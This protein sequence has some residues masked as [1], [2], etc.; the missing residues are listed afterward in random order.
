MPTLRKADRRMTVRLAAIATTAVLA[1]GFHSA[2]IAQVKKV[3]P[4]TLVI[5]QSPWFAGFKGLVDYY[6]ETTGNQIK[7]DVNPFAGS[8]EKQRNSARAPASDI[9]L[10]I[11]NAAIMAE[12]WSSGLVN[13]MDEIDPDFKL[14]PQISTFA[15]TVCWD[16]AKASYDCSSGKLIGVPINPNVQMLYYRTDLYEEKGLSVPK[17][18]ADLAS[19]AAALNDPPS[20]F[21]IVQRGSRQGISYNFRPYLAGSGASIFADPVAGDYTVTVNSDAAK[22]ALSFYVGLA[23]EGGHP[24]TGAIAM[25]DMIQLMATGKAA[26]MIAVIAAFSQLDDPDKSIIAGKFNVAVVP[27]SPSTPTLGHFIS[28]IPKNIPQ[29]KKEAVVEFLKWFMTK[30]AQIKYAEVGGVPVRD[31]VL[32]S[33]LADKDQFRWMRPLADSL[34]VA[35]IYYDIPQGDEI[36][37]ILELKLNQAVIGELTTEQALDEA[38]A[39]IRKIVKDAGLNGNN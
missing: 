4:F 25:G 26:Q 15:D 6:I 12:L 2:A 14:D 1:I 16:A 32:R 31:D 39:E 38:A 13:S 34:K 11:T 37:G 10:F 23:K 27:G 33:D 20:L 8:L 21:G 17:T 3:E 22:D 18:L 35:E 29:E 30:D 36:N 5:N 24:N 28:S 7:L 19:N 9:D